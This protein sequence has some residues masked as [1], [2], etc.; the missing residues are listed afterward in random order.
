MPGRIGD[1]GL[2][3]IEINSSGIFNYR[4]Q[5]RIC[6]RVN[7]EFDKTIGTGLVYIAVGQHDVFKQEFGITRTCQVEPV[8]MTARA[9]AYGAHIEPGRQGVRDPNSESGVRAGVLETDRILQFGAGPD[10][11]CSAV[12]IWKALFVVRIP[13]TYILFTVD[14]DPGILFVIR[15]L[16]NKTG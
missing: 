6:T 14:I 16:C 3:Q 4:F 12:T 8:R 7:T 15:E 10:I 11:V 1:D 9:G 2:I 5:R 13:G